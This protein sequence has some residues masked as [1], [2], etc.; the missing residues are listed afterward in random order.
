MDSVRGIMATNAL[1]I[2]PAILKLFIKQE[3]KIGKFK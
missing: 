3:I 1:C 2:I